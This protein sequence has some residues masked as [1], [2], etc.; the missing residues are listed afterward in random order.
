MALDVESGDE[1]ELVKSRSGS[2]DEEATKDVAMDDDDGSS[3]SDFVPGEQEKGKS[4]EK[5][6]AASGSESESD[7]EEEDEIEEE[8]EEEKPSKRSKGKGK[9]TAKPKAPKKAPQERKVRIIASGNA[10]DAPRVVSQKTASATPGPSQSQTV[11]VSAASGARRHHKWYSLPSPSVHHRHRAVPLFNQTNSRVR[12]MTA[13][14]KL[15]EEPETAETNGFTSN[16]KVSDRVGKSWGYNVGPGPFWELCEDR[17]WFKEYCM[18]DNTAS[19]EMSKRKRAHE[20]VSVKNGWKLLNREQASSYLPADTTTT[21]SGQL[22]P[23]PPVVCSFG[24]FGSQ[25]KLEVSAFTAFP[26]AQYVPESKSHVFNAGAP[27]WGMDWCPIH[28]DDRRIRPSQYLAVSAFPSR[29]HSPEIGKRR[30]TGAPTP[31]NIQIWSLSPTKEKAANQAKPKSRKGKAKATNEDADGDQVMSDAQGTEDIGKMRCEMVLCLES[32]PAHSLK[33]IPLPTH[34]S[35]AEGQPD[36]IGTLGL[37]S[38][39][40]E[41]GTFAIYAVPDPVD[42][43]KGTTPSE[44]PLFVHLPA[45][46]L[47]IELEAETSCWSFDWA[48]S[49]VVAIGTTGGVIAVYDLGPA[50]TSI[51]SPDTP[52]LTPTS[53]PHLLFPTHY[54][55]VHQSAI[56]A[57]AWI[58]APPQWYVLQEL[59]KKKGKGPEPPAGEDR[60][61]DSPTVIASGGFDGMECMTDIRE[62]RGV[63]MNRTRD[64]I[65]A[66]TF[67]PYSGGTITIDHENIVKAYSAS[68]K[69]LGRG[70]LLMEPQG[71][72]VSSSDYHAQ[73]AVGSADGSC[74]TTNTLRSTRRDGPVPFFVHKIYQLDYN[75]NLKEYRMLDRFLSMETSDKPTV[76]L[77][78]AKDKAKTKTKTKSAPPQPDWNTG[79]WPQEVGVQLVTWNSSNGLPNSGLLASATGSG[80]CRVDYLWGRWIKDRRPYVDI[81]TIRMEGMVSESSSES[82]SA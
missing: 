60:V 56:R 8:E 58:R 22:K 76:G 41:D 44:D 54:I 26:M 73:L 9:A 18:S 70:H 14:P 15:F 12:R 79:A 48:N 80:L 55:T 50:L 75:R 67:A 43:H 61:W 47:K 6:R 11:S 24:P 74:T 45:P 71:P 51:S 64:V 1:V 16:E 53:H 46:I 29:Q 10:V 65:N 28:G 23:P 68:P 32:G 49:E 21:E 42:M 2:H 66:M 36:R 35:F 7:S 78:K 72:S 33:W 27:V 37:L 25:T 57:V 30:N 13:A 17:A 77:Q 40:F 82:E 4:K 5:G 81:E 59:E 3:G 34:S 20:N 62:G 69:M 63:V 38:G 31:G 39:T 19:E 52:T